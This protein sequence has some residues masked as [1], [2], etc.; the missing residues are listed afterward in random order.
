MDIYQRAQR[1]AI[2]LSMPTGEVQTDELVRNAL[3]SGKQVFV[4]YLYKSRD[5]VTEKLRSVMEMVDLQSVHDY[6]S[7]ERD[8]WGIPTISKDTVEAR[9]HILRDGKS[10][11]LMFMPGLGFDPRPDGQP[12]KRIGHG[13]GFYDRF[14]HAYDA[15]MKLQQNNDS[16]TGGEKGLMLFGLALEEQVLA[17]PEGTPVPVD[18]HDIP[19]HGLFMGAGRVLG[20]Y[21]A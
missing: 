19:V 6:E 17:G 21:S 3:A 15:T 7:L 4:P 11:D 2:Y 9:E 18:R 10:L 13:K 5:P 1:I 8:N 16:S 12:I 20:P 14:L